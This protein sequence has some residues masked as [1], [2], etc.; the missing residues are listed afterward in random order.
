MGYADLVGTHLANVAMVR[1]P[2]R[3]EVDER[4]EYDAR[5]RVFLEMRRTFM[6]LHPEADVVTLLRGL[7]R[8][9]DGRRALRDRARALELASFP[10][11]KRSLLRTLLDRHRND[12]AIVFTA[13][14]ENAYDAARDNLVPVITGETGARERQEILAAFRDGRVR[15]IASARVLN[16]G[17]DVPE[18]RVAIIVA[19]A[20][21]PREHV[22]RIGRVLR[23]A[24]D[25][26]ALVYELVTTN[27]SD[28][29]RAQQRARYA[30]RRS[31]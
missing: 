7:G 19:G 5:M 10:R 22:Q 2:V 12:R 8:T 16:E 25:K 21:G 17:I 29:R 30:P 9:P 3:L 4:A 14:A 24:P 31:T 6:R 26:E 23:P 20:L 15:A 1:V 11:A 13:F 27:T 28:A 18:A